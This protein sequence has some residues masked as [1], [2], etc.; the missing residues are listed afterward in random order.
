MTPQRSENRG[1]SGDDNV[2]SLEFSLTC[3]DGSTR[4]IGRELDDHG[5]WVASAGRF[6]PGTAHAVAAVDAASV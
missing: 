5:A 4:L 3:E 1:P 6:R 2:C